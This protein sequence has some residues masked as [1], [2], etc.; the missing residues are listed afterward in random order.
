MDSSFLPL[1]WHGRRRRKNRAP[2][3]LPF[4]PFLIIQDRASFPL[5]PLGRLLKDRRHSPF[6]QEGQLSPV[7]LARELGFPF[8]A[9]PERTRFPPDPPLSSPV[10]R[11]C[12]SSAY[13]KVHGLTVLD[14]PL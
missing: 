4:S 13:G 1:N 3:T 9:L 11:S 5:Y 10:R 8:L 7:R 2:L 14:G 12:P 6:T